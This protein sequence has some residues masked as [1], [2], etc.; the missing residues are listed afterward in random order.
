M[1]TF[2]YVF[3]VAVVV[4]LISSAIGMF[5]VG[6]YTSKTIPLILMAMAVASIT[7]GIYHKFLVKEKDKDE[8][9]IAIENRAKAKAFDI[10]EIVFGILVISY[11]FLRVNLLTIFLAIAA[12]LVIFASYMVSFSKYHKEM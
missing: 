12:Y 6:G 9:N 7:N 3:I 10:M 11:V 2:N 8:R 5:F 1:K 4:M